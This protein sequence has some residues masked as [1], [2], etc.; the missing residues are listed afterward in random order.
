MYGEL[1]YIT[2][3]HKKLPGNITGSEV[4]GHR[5]QCGAAHVLKH[6]WQAE[7]QVLGIAAKLFCFPFLHRMRQILTETQTHDQGQQR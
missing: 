3:T 7:V 6:A 1:L 4:R 2:P 5:L